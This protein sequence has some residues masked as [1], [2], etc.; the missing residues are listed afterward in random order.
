MLFAAA[1]LL[2][3]AAAALV[4]Y[5]RPSDLPEGP[6]PDPAAHLEGRKTTIY[7]NLRDL[8]FE[9]RLGKLSEADYQKTKTG[10]QNELARVMAEIDRLRGATDALR[11]MAAKPAGGPGA[12]AGKTVKEV[13]AAKPACPKC[14]ATFDKPMKFCGECGAAM[15]EVRG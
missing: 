14:G 3:A 4:I 12:V 8:G 6:P 13:K 2:I 10:L 5:I 7:E 11:A 15:G 9:F 1:F